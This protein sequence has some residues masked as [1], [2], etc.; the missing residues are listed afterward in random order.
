ME[1]K[2]LIERA[3]DKVGS[4]KALAELIGE[5]PTHLSAMKAGK[6]YCGYRK[7]AQMAALIGENPAR[8]II[9][10]IAEEL[11]DEVPHEA[12]A[13]KALSAILSAFPAETDEPH[14]VVDKRW[15]KR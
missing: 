4:Q 10:A 11:R 5:I 8:T 14:E 12:E 3:A 15:R 7:R 13:K 2:E 9:A 6:R 1:I